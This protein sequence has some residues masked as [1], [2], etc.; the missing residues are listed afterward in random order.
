MLQ[1]STSSTVDKYVE[2]VDNG[3]V[4]KTV[5]NFTTDT[6]QNK[7]ITIKNSGYLA[8]ARKHTVTAQGQPL[9]LCNRFQVL[10][11]LKDSDCSSQS[12]WQSTNASFNLKGYKN[13]KG[14]ALGSAFLY[15]GQDIT[16]WNLSILSRVIKTKQGK[17]R[18][19]PCIHR[20]TKVI[21]VTH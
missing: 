10:A 21:S 4:N 17:Y 11:Q 6:F 13:G 19:L 2:I 16:R 20:I 8:A 9:P 15:G 18:V 3:A 14:Q 1:Q 7:P 12:S 5:R